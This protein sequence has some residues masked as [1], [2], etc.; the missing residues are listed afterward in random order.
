MR[1]CEANFLYTITRIRQRLFAFIREELSKKGVDGMAPSHGDILFV[2]DRKG[3]VTMQDLARRTL[4]DKSTVSSVINRMVELGY[5]V[6][7]KDS[8][9]ARYTNLT[10]TPKA[11]G[12]RPVLYGISQRMNETLFRGF[13]EEEKRTL[14]R[15]MEKMYANL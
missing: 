4:K 1:I 15:L 9:D 12:L 14:F 2:L 10:L 11:E 8:I 3:P 5:I 13:S 7:E 6:K